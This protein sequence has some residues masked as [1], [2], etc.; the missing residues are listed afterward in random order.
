M[1]LRPKKSLA[2]QGKVFSLCVC[3]CAC[4]PPQSDWVRVDLSH[5]LGVL[6]IK[7]ERRFD[8]A[9]WV[10]WVK[11]T[12]AARCASQESTR[13]TGFTSARQLQSTPTAGSQLLCVC[14][15]MCVRAY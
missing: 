15:C 11:N 10:P 12:R 2:S 6:C 7:K 9:F 8:V 3:V 1:F 4:V 14:V 5:S 13:L